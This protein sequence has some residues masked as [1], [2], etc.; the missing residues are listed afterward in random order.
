[1]P[2]R[3]D[4]LELRI[5]IRVGGPFERLLQGLEAIAEFMQQP[6]HRSG[7]HAP[8]LSCQ[9]CGELRLTLARPAQWGRRVAA[10]HGLHQCLE[11]SL[12][13][14]LCAGAPPSVN[15]RRPR[16][17]VVGDKPV[18]DETSASPPYPI[19]TDSAAAHK[20]RARSF[21]S[22]D[23]AAY[24]ATSVASRSVSRLNDHC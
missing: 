22:D 12:Q 20:R 13:A 21:N 15:S 23:K 1:L 10:G 6:P 3:V 18:A 5:P 16:R 4:V 19:A 9:C 11:C 24:L 7:T 8:T 17:I 14:R 2:S